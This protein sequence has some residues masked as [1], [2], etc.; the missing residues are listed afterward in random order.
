MTRLSMRKLLCKHKP[1]GCSCLYIIRGCFCRWA[2][3]WDIYLNMS[4]VQI[5][6][7]SIVN[8]VVV[9]FFLS[10]IITMIIIRTLRRY[11]DVLFLKTI[12]L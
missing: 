12:L 8:S 1:A 5:H 10:G 9:V 2:S 4:D 3:R 6:W 11:S 7:F